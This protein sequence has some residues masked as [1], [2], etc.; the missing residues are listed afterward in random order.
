[1]PLAATPKLLTTIC[2]AAMARSGSSAARASAAMVPGLM[3]EDMRPP[4]F[5]TLCG[6]LPRC[7]GRFLGPRSLRHAPMESMVDEDEQRA[8]RSGEQHNQQ[9]HRHDELHVL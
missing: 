2:S 3:I 8:D 5:T 1:M 6:Q 9:R 4:V 7:R